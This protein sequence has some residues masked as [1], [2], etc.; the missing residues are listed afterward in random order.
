[1]NERPAP[2]S[3]LRFEFSKA[4]PLIGLQCAAS[5][6]VPLV[7]GLSTGHPTEGG[8]GAVG[9][10]LTDMAIFQPGHRFR[11][12]IVLGAAALVALGSYLGA[13]VGIRSPAIY[14]VV[15]VWT[16]GAGLCVAIGPT[17][18][19][20]GVS[21]ATGVAYAA[22]L[23]VSAR[24]AF[25]LGLV[26]LA[27]GVA[28]TAIA[29]TI[30]W[31][32]RWFVAPP[33]PS[34]RSG[35]QWARDAL[36][37]VR[38]GLTGQ[39]SVRHHTIRLTVAVLVGTVLFRVVNPTDG[40]WIPEATLFIMRPDIGL[41]WRRSQLRVL[42]T[43]VG[44]TLTTLLLVTLRPSPA[45]MATIAVIA[46]VIAFSVQ[47]VNFGLYITFVTCI[48]V[49]LTAFG[50]LPPRSAVLG[51]LVDNLIGA[52]LA[53]AALALWPGDRRSP[54]RGP[55]PGAARSPRPARPPDGG[56]APGPVGPPV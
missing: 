4:S 46:S 23:D 56:M 43:I 27:S 47:R 25:G 55:D 28:T 22:S 54:S 34:G 7:V 52:A 17:A 31:V 12:R 44:V 37:S 16:V 50:G 42:G 49:F 8:W 51:R 24:Q 10:F 40:F 3:I 11:A 15:A 35:I 13:L 9:A 30:H 32:E 53:V 5:L 2:Q 20:V 26:M 48:F 6:A 33:V 38:R 1:M 29:F 41:T 21:S 18:A 45:E 36:A 14:A 19:L 39:P